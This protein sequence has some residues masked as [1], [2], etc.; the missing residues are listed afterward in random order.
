[1]NIKR[2]EFQISSKLSF[3]KGKCAIC[4]TFVRE[5]SGLNA[6]NKIMKCRVG[7]AYSLLVMFFLLLYSIPYNI[8]YY[9]YIYTI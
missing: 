7:L 4:Y 8:V 2:Q 5:F 6:I 3:V 9:I 1:M